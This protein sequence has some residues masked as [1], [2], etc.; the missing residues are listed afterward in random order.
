MTKAKSPVRAYRTIVQDSGD[1][2]YVNRVLIA[3]PTTG[4]VRI[5][6]VQSRYG[7]IIPANWSSVQMTEWMNSYIPLRYQVDDAQNMIVKHLVEGDFEWLLL[8]EHDTCP[9]PDAFIRFN[10]YMREEKVPVV[11]GLYY[12][13]SRPSEPLVYRGRGTGAY[14]D[15]KIGDAVWCDGV[16]TGCLLIHGG[17]LREMWKESP[18]YAIRGVVTRRVFDTPRLVY[19]DSN[20]N[21]FAQSGTS[22]LEWCT[23]VMKGEFFEKAGWKKYQVMQYPFLVDTNIF[24]RHINP[25]GEAFP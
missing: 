25:D 16:P 19:Q 10:Q 5:E 6:W 14:T 23:R 15:F 18:E 4:L 8:I 3:T 22:D 12:T 2:G 11:S 7:Q 9:P 20:G 21:S 1:P 24:C 13:R 17:I